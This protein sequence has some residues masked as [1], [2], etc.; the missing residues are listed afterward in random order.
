MVVVA[1]AVAVGVR[2][3]ETEVG[4]EAVPDGL[5]GVP[6]GEESLLPASYERRRLNQLQLRK[7]KRQG[8]GGSTHPLERS[9]INQPPI[10]RNLINHIPHPNLLIPRPRNSILHN[11]RFIRIHFRGILLVGFD[12][13]DYRYSFLLP[14]LGAACAFFVGLGALGGEGGGGCGGVGVGVGGRGGEEGGEGVVEGGEV[15]FDRVGAV[16]EDEDLVDG[17]HGG[18]SGVDNSGSRIIRVEA[19]RGMSICRLLREENRSN[20]SFHAS[21]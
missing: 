8:F 3:R 17:G 21:H 6:G 10:I 1:V 14:P 16:V 18:D 7:V 19:E 12:V 5:L 4:E 11:L 20:I 2:G 15:G 13:R 9:P